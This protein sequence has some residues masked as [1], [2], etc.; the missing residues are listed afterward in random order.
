MAGAARHKERRSSPVSRVGL[1]PRQME[2]AL[3]MARRHSHKEIARKLG[4]RPNTTRRHERAVLTRLGVRSRYQVL[5]ALTRLDT[6]ET[7]HD[8]TS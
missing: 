6:P 8:P 5:A 7:T 2:I 4:I 1:T 3:L